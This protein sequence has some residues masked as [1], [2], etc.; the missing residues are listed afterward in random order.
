MRAIALLFLAILTCA[1]Q[2]QALG[3]P[4]SN[5]VAYQT[6]FQAKILD[7]FVKHVGREGEFIGEAG[8][9]IRFIVF[10]N[11]SA[12]RSV[13]IV[14]GSGEN[15]RKYFE[16]AYDFYNSGYTVFMLDNR[17]QGASGRLTADPL[18]QYLDSFENFVKDL[19]YFHDRIVRFQAPG[20]RYLLGH[21]MG[22]C[23]STYYAE[24]YPED[25]TAI[26]L[27]APM[28]KIK[29][30]DHGNAIPEPL[31]LL[32]LA[33]KVTFEKK[34]EELVKPEDDPID[35]TFEANA[36]THSRARFQMGLDTVL[37]QPS[38]RLSKLS[39]KWM[40][41]AISASVA[42]RTRDWAA[43]ANVPILLLQA[44]QDQ[45][46]L[47]EG[48]NEFC[49]NAPNCRLEVIKGTGHE[50]LQESDSIR[51]PAIEKI[52]KFFESH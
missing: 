21:S 48:Q 35:H 25:F 45:L 16:I 29:L 14:N 30:I 36:L 24:M 32:M 34:G 5:P 51:T 47:P 50:I 2:A 39:N 17:G 37:L 52:L 6:D 1:F 43:G 40:Q 19:K 28:H 11:P 15:Y 41:E 4:D 27:N 49:S 20:P 31:A 46:I 44:E 8:I 22:G 9:R 12:N 10:K 26:A 3:L 18:L 38:L 42:V 33:W 7:G 13:T 23:I